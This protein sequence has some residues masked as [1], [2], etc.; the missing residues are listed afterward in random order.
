[1]SNSCF[2]PRNSDAP[3]PVNL[4]P[5]I[6]RLSSV[7]SGGTSETPAH[8]RLVIEDDSEWV[9]RRLLRKLLPPDI[10]SHPTISTSRPGLLFC[11]RRAREAAEPEDQ[12]QRKDRRHD[13]FRDVGART[14]SNYGR[15]IVMVLL[16]AS[17]PVVTITKTLNEATSPL[18]ARPAA[19]LKFVPVTLLPM[20]VAVPAS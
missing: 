1:M 5:S 2:W 13:R 10:W 11:R 18:L 4:S 9:G 17:L 14:P 7:K 15:V 20:T 16:S 12:R 19:V 3:F 8:H 6:V